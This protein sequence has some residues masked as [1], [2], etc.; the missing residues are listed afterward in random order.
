MKSEPRTECRTPTPNKNSTTIPSWKFDALAKLVLQVVA[1]ANSVGLL[2]SELPDR[3]REELSS[4]VLDKLGSLGWHVTTVK[5]ELEVR[6][7]LRRIAGVTPQ[8]LVL[9]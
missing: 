9:G 8:R 1:D 5:L 4:D 6:G 7:D 2:F 3:V